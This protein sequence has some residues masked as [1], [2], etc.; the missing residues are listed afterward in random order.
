MQSEHLTN[1]H[2]GWVVAGWL[3]AVAATAALY[4]GGVGAGFVGPDEGVALWVS[5]SMAG[6]FFV[7]GLLVGMR[8]SD[9]PILHGAAI[10]FV[11]VLVWFALGL[12]GAPGGAESA[13]LVLGLILLQLVAACS[14]GWAGRRAT[15]GSGKAE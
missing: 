2:P 13:P 9:A 12:F 5:V 7:G 1:L 3:I 11:S 8:W 6:G 10:T 14:G 4:L 15:L